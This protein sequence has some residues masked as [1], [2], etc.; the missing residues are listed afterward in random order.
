MGISV[1]LTLLVTLPVGVV[2]GG[3]GVSWWVGR[4]RYGRPREKKQ[5]LGTSSAVY[6]DPALL[7]TATVTDISLSQNQAY[8]HIN[9]R[10]RSS[11]V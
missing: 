8:G 7:D 9:T 6:E 2:I 1:A 3:V 10:Q 4:A 11:G 5:S